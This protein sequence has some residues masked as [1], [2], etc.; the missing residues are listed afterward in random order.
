MTKPIYD[1]MKCHDGTVRAVELINGVLIDPSLP[2]KSELSEKKGGEKK[3]KL[4]I[5]IQDRIQNQ[6]ENYISALEGQVDDFVNSDY[7]MK[8]GILL[9][10]HH[11]LNDILVAHIHES[12]QLFLKDII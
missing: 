3:T 6:V 8:G 5:S 2:K 9:A 11:G 4:K 10:C 12:I 1:I 7:V